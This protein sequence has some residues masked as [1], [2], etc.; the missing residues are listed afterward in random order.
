MDTYTRTKKK[1][2]WVCVETNN[3][4]VLIL[5]AASLFPTRYTLFQGIMGDSGHESI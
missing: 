5:P 4:P 1:A 2:V 3:N